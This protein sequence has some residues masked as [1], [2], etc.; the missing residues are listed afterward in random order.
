MYKDLSSKTKLF[1]NMLIAQLGFSSISLVSILSDSQ[2]VFILTVNITFALIVFYMNWAATKRIV[3][4]IER[5]KNYMDDIMDYLSMKNN[6]IRKAK[7]M[8]NDE[9]GIIL[10][11]L[12]NYVD[13][14]EVI[15]KEDMK[16]VG[17]VVLTLDKISKGTY[18][19]K[20]NSNSDNFMIN[21]LKTTVNNMIDNTQ[22]SMDNL[23]DVLTS[24]SNN[25]FRDKIN[26]PSDL[27]DE[28]LVVMQAVNKLGL[29]LNYNAEENLK[30]G[31]NLESDSLIMTN[32]SKNVALR[33]NEQAAS[34][35]EVAAALD[36]ISS[37][38]S[39]NAEN[40]AVMAQ[41]GVKVKLSVENGQTLANRT[42]V[43]MDE[44]NKEVVSINEAITV[45]DEI[46]FQ[47]NILSLNAAVEAATAG[48]SG[49]GFAVVAQEV[50]NLANRS[51]I[52][53]KEIKALV[54]YAKVKA[55]N[56]K[57]ISDEMILGYK[58]L[59]INISKT[60]N[61]IDDVS[62]ASKEQI[63]GIEQINSS[64]SSLDRVTQENAS[65]ANTVSKISNKTLSLAQNLLLEAKNKKIYIA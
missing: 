37:I 51:A 17:E 63:L 30:N 44:I 31:Q 48:E 35:E 29:A 22:Y 55:N 27:H 47:T 3:G 9:I 41:L 15:R 42:S 23:K 50:R 16:V 43:A 5:F 12:N 1:I 6:K 32:A 38:T 2:V 39:S 13:K 49:K 65:E 61:I 14:F 62:K 4:G 33:A 56:G 54:E 40:A 58:E 52:A 21:A 7:Y 57:K 10:T 46:A 24:Y 20:V 18:S 34:L 45:I 26:I 53:A 19:T 25:D 8:K 11:E 36:E 60:I 64:V 59:N 28:M